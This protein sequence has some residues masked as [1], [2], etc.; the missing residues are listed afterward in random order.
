ML[1]QCLWQHSEPMAHA[2]GAQLKGA[3]EVLIE[4]CVVERT[5]LYGIAVGFNL[6]WCAPAAGCLTPCMLPSC[7]T[8]CGTPCAA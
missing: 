7:T 3:D 4:N 8:Q 6:Y 5:N 2:G 1:A